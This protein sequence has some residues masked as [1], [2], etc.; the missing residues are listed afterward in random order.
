MSIAVRGCSCLASMSS[1][2][3]D[4]CVCLLASPARSLTCQDQTGDFVN[5]H[6]CQNKACFCVHTNHVYC[7]LHLAT[8]SVRRLWFLRACQAHSMPLSLLIC[9]SLIT[10]L[11]AHWQFQIK[12]HRRLYR[13]SI[14][15]AKLLSQMLYPF[16]LLLT[17]SRHRIPPRT[18][19]AEA[20]FCFS[21]SL[22]EFKVLLKRHL[23]GKLVS[24]VLFYVEDLCKNVPD[25]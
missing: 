1:N 9:V 12:L 24:F 3:I 5:L 6:H 4:I 15:I 10:I 20:G 22:F 2:A 11:Y 18:R 16:P 14:S 8:L 23:A 19:K 25:I 17:L 13:F 21:N 7:S